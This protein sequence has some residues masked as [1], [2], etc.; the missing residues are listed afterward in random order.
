MNEFANQAPQ[1]LDAAQACG[2]I[3]AP[4]DEAEVQRRQ[5]E[6]MCANAVQVLQHARQIRADAALM[7]DVRAHI[8]KLRD[9]GAALLD[10]IGG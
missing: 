6:Y 4:I 2:V 10:D 5:R 7:A 3:G 9:D 1:Y 8:R